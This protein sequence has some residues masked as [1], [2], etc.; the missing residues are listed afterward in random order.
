MSKLTKALIPGYGA[1]PTKPNSNPLSGLAPDLETGLPQGLPSG[2]GK[3]A[4]RYG[5]PVGGMSPDING[6]ISYHK[7]F[8][9]NSSNG[10]P[11]APAAGPQHTIWGDPDMTKR[12]WGWGMDSTGKLQEGVHG[13]GPNG[14]PFGPPGSTTGANGGYGPGMPGTPGAPGNT[15]VA[16]PTS[17]PGMQGPMSPGQGMQIAQQMRQ[18]AGQGGSSAN[19]PG[20]GAYMQ[21]QGGPAMGQGGMQGQSGMGGQPGTPG[22]A[23]TAPQQFPAQVPGT[24]AYGPSQQGQ[25]VQALIAQL[26]QQQ[27]QVGMGQSAQ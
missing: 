7:G 12:G 11:D 2:I 19:T 18:G 15:G 16:S 27:P 3:A 22:G 17:M 4:L 5:N 9:D 24:P 20:M 8:L 23:F 14:S 21:S 26:R 13:G 1:N 10:T 25:G 6:D